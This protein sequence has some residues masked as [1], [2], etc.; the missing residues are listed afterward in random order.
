MSA[1]RT[2]DQIDSDARV[3]D[4]LAAR[5]WQRDLL[6]NRGGD[7]L[8]NLAN[9]VSAL[10]Y[11]PELS[12]IVALDT[13]GGRPMLMSRPPWG[14]EPFTKRPWQDFDEGELLGWLQRVG[15]PVYAAATVAD[16][17]RVVAQRH[18]FDALADYLSGLQ[19]D[20]VERLSVWLVCY[21]GAPDTP[22]IAA[23]GRAWLISAAARGL[24]P[25]CQADHAL[26]LEG[27]QG[28]GKTQTARILGGEWTQEH[29]PD[30]HSKDAEAG[31]AGSWVVELAELAALT[32]SEAESIKSFLTRRVDR[33]RPPYARHTVEQP[34]RCVF[35]GTTNEPRYLRDATGNRRFWPVPIGTMNPEALARDRDQLFAEAVVAFRAGEPWWLDGEMKQQAEAEQAARMESDPWL[36]VIAQ[37]ITGKSET[38]T[39]QLLN[40]IDMPGGRATAAHAK[41]IAGIMRQE[42]WSERVDKSGGGR[43]VT[44]TRQAG[45]AR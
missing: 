18:R 45:Q 26:M 43:E 30:L 12:G 33:F 36:A 3:I 13:F 15:V 42:G 41:R 29:L 34:R 32:K 10:E 40:R 28:A 7:I 8:G 19:W 20:G 23:I 21:L 2:P 6:K 11:A 24:Q 16:S 25:G 9:V 35:L 44:W 31:L 22:L 14:G 38:T 39:R 17:V 1:N 37:E 4:E 5:R 27:A